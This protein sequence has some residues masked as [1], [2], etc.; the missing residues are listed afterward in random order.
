MFDRFGE[1]EILFFELE[2]DY[3]RFEGV[4][5]NSVENQELQKELTSLVFDEEGGIKLK[6]FSRPTRDWDVFVRCG[7]IP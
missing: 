3:S 4:L 7:F 2:G 1:G 6:S 5:I